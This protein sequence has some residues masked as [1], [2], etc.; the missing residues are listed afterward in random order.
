MAVPWPVVDLGVGAHED[1]VHH[2]VHENALLAEED[3]IVDVALHC[4]LTIGLHAAAEGGGGLQLDL[5]L[6]EVTKEAADEGVI[7]TCESQDV[8]AKGGAPENAM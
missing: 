1:A 5:L 3:V 4:S 6:D 2:L 8:L 7:C